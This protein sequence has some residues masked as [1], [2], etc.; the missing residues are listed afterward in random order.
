MTPRQ[1]PQEE[2]ASLVGADALLDNEEENLKFS[3]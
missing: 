1:R 2:G 3:R